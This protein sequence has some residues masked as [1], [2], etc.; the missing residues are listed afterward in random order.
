LGFGVQFATLVLLTGWMEANYLLA[1]AWE[2]PSN[3]PQGRGHCHT[4]VAVLSQ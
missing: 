4:L 2:R 3:V 1:T